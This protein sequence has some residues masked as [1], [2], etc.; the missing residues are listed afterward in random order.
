M[1]IALSTLKF[2]TRSDSSRDLWS[3]G[4]GNTEINSNRSRLGHVLVEKMDK[5]W[6]SNQRK[7]LNTSRV[8]LTSEGVSLWPG[9]GTFRNSKLQCRDTASTKLLEAWPR[10]NMKRWMVEKPFVTELFAFHVFNGSI[11]HIKLPCQIPSRN[12]RC[13]ALS[14]PPMNLQILSGSSYQRGK[15]LK[16]CLTWK[17]RN[18]FTFNVSARARRA[19]EL[20]PSAWISFDIDIPTNRWSKA[21][22]R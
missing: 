11:K 22:F 19:R 3:R 7:I 2:L 5:C 16:P 15:N 8:G 6:M 10:V 1:P 21:L 13:R 17:S 20:F 12:C 9:R 14:G 18:R 4:W